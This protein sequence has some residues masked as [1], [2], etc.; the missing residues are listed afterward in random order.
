[1]VTGEHKKGIILIGLGLLLLALNDW[2]TIRLITLVFAL[3]LINYGLLKMGK[4][5]LVDYARNA[6]QALKFW[7]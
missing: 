2:V 7:K 5:S 1:M 4:S 6:L 3:M